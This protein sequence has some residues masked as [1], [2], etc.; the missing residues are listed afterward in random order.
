MSSEERPQA[1]AIRSALLNA[2]ALF[3]SGE[4]S[5]EPLLKAARTILNRDAPLGRIDYLEI[6]D[7]E[8]MQ[9]IARIDERP[10]LIAVAV[11]FGECRLI[12]NIELIPRATSSVS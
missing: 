3:D 1:A 11:F 8:T 12:D 5:A 6:V 4:Q 7:A 9:R 10:G 2:Q